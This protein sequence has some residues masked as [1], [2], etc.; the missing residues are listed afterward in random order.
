MTQ[1]FDSKIFLSTV[2]SRP[3]V[4]Q[5]LNK[6]NDIIYIGKAKNL[7]KRLTS[8]FRKNTSVKTN[9]LVSQINEIQVVITDTE[10]D[11]LILESNL[12]KKH[13][14]R[15]NI[16]FRDDKSYPYVYAAI[17]HAFPCLRFYR[18]GRNLPGKYFGPFPSVGSVR[19]TLNLLQKVFLLRSCNDIFFK[20][21]TRPCLQYQIK[22]CSAPCVDY[23]SAAN[24]EQ[25]FQNALAFLE[26]KN[27]Q[28]LAALQV[29]MDQAAKELNYELAAKYRDQITNLRMIQKNQYMVK[30]K[31]N[32]DLVVVTIKADLACVYLL[33]IRE[34]RILGSKVFFPDIKMNEQQDEELLSAFIKQYY[35]NKINDLPDIIVVN[36]EVS[37]KTLLEQALQ[38]QQQRKIRLQRVSRGDL[39]KWYTLAERSAE[40]SILSRLSTRKNYHKKFNKLK[41]ELKLENEIQRIECFDISHH[42]GEATVASCVVFETQGPVNSLY[43]HFNIENSTIGDDY[44]AMREVL[45]RRYLK[46]KKSEGRLPDLLLIDGGK[47]QLS[48]AKKVMEELQLTDIPICAIAKGKT[49]KPGLETLFL[50]EQDIPIILSP[51]SPSLHLLQQVR[52]EAH[53]FAITHNRSKIKKARNTSKLETIP[54]I[55]TKRRQALLKHFGGIQ[56]VMQASVEEIAR[57][58]GIS[59]ELAQIIYDALQP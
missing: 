49:R 25:D 58:P 29:K 20:N 11:A 37:E 22:R 12:I 45:T 36:S 38:A 3:G 24:Y 54:G 35:L 19:E 32:L 33:I 15:Y 18:G 8:Y 34:G 42:R 16:L 23:I 28:L 47:G 5:M 50:S 57:A 51:D 13:Q 59:H 14:P 26:G 6:N 46:I 9:S 40:Q 27:E 4:Y 31:R 30:G 43:R 48:E 10:S 41:E 7:K 55:G 52:D 21:R 53:R 1:A 2:S 17:S 44:A 39:S 56:A